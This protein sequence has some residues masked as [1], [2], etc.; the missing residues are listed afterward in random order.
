ML[1]QVSSELV[2]HVGLEPGLARVPVAEL[3][4]VVGA[5]ALAGG[6]QGDAVGYKV[7]DRIRDVQD[8]PNGCTLGG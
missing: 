5:T 6:E 4:R 7:L 8:P 2:A 3:T 1:G